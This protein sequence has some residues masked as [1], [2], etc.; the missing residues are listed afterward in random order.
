MDGKIGRIVKKKPA[1]LRIQ[2]HYA[3][4][5]AGTTGRHSEGSQTLDV[6]MPTIM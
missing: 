4:A 6:P 2:G 3:R 5:V 1:R